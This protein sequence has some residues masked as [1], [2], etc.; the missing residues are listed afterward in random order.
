MTLLI[1]GLNSV[2]I[3]SLRR[4]GRGENV[5]STGYGR[6]PSTAAARDELMRRGLV[7]E[8]ATPKGKKRFFIMTARGRTALPEIAM[9]D[10]AEAER[11][12]QDA[13]V[14][15][16]AERIR[17]AGPALLDALQALL[18]ACSD[19]G[20]DSEDDETFKAALAR[21]AAAMRAAQAAI[22]AAGARP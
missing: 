17:N 13:L 2:A 5:E 9:L 22:N 20:L 18:T 6:M 21:Q 3:N 10:E 19:A 1:D 11:R 7:S 14:A 15:A 4:L 8:Q 12:G 16:A